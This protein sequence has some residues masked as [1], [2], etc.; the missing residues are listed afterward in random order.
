[1]T[2]REAPVTRFKRPF[3]FAP[4]RRLRAF[5]RNERAAV[6]NVGR[7]RTS[8]AERAR[9]PTETHERARPVAP[10]ATT[11]NCCATVDF[12]ANPPE[13]WKLARA[14]KLVYDCLTT[15]E[16]LLP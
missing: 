1:M 10:P 8:E 14:P 15:Y 4:D 7:V 5:G 11:T 6:E 13:T 3:R 2:R 16:G 9:A 12:F